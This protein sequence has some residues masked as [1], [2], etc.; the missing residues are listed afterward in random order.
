[1]IKKFKRRK[2]ITQNNSIITE[3]DFGDKKLAEKLLTEVRE[4][5]WGDLRKETVVALR[6]LLETM[7]EIEVQDLNGNKF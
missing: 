5:L 6:K 3:L 2:H 1:M 4:D 7:V